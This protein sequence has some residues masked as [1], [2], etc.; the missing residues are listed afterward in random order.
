MNILRHIK[1]RA[2]GSKLDLWY[3][4]EGNDGPTFWINYNSGHFIKETL[5]QFTN[6][7]DRYNKELYGGDII[8]FQNKD[9]NSYIG[10]VFFDT[11]AA[12]YCVK[13]K[14]DDN[15]NHFVFD[16]SRLNNKSDIFLGFEI[17][18][19]MIDNSDLFFKKV[20][21]KVV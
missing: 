3:Y 14:A 15:G 4:S 16:L 5:G 12:K 8:K 13:T 11:N 18:G 1:F 7:R 10:V 9:S 6:L 17:I 2:K 21:N 20:K 19:N